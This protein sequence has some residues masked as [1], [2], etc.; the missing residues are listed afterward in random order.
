[1]PALAR[2]E[3]ADTVLDDVWRRPGPTL[4]KRCARYPTLTR[5]CPALN[6]SRPSLGRHPIGGV[7]LNRIHVLAASII[8]GLSA[9][10]GVAAARRRPPYRR[11]KPAVSKVSDQ[12]I[13]ARQRSST[14]QKLRSHGRA[15]RSRRRSLRRP[16]AA[17]PTGS[18]APSR[19]AIAVRRPTSMTTSTSDD[20]DE[21]ER[22]TMTSPVGRDLRHGAHALHV[23]PDVGARGR[24]SLAGEGGRRDRPTPAGA[25]AREK[26]LRARASRRSGSS[27]R[28]WATYRAQLAKRN[29][30]IAAAEQ[31]QPPLRRPVAF[32]SSAAPAATATRSS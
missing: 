21:H 22:R 1:M 4:P 24:A 27:K 2:G 11:A 3:P 30:Q 13:A 6:R 31:A 14:A 32:R 15:P 18:S 28:R 5:G 7:P 26:K 19:P 25:A 10:F 29:S 23:L 20:E 9:I 17:I 12:A 16:C 8:V